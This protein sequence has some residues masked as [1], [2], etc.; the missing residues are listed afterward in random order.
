MAGLLVAV[1]FIEDGSSSKMFDED[2][3][4]G[5]GKDVGLAILE[6]KHLEHDLIQALSY[7]TFV[8]AR[9]L[10]EYSIGLGREE[11]EVVPHLPPG[12]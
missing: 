10:F 11:K 1:K 9:E 6:L 12:Q 4:K 7:N 3:Y 2:F 8:T 5:V